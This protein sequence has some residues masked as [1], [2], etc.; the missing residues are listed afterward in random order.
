MSVAL[1]LSLTFF[2]LNKQMVLADSPDCGLLQDCTMNGFYGNSGAG[3]G[4]WKVFK[5]SGTPGID[6]APVEGWPS[7]PSVHLHG[8]D[9]PFDAGILQTVAVT[10]GLGY[11][12]DLAW[13]VETIGGKGWHDGYQIN[14][15]LGIDPLG[16]VDANS[17]NVQWSTDY[18]GSGKFVLALDAYAQAPLM[19]VFVRVINPYTDQV[20]DVYLD[21]ASL[22]VNSGMAPITV[23]APATT[24]PSPTAAPSSTSRP[25]RE[26]TVIALAPSPTEVALAP[27][28]TELPTDAPAPTGVVE[29]S[30]TPETSATSTRLPTRVRRLTPTPIA[31]NGDTTRTQGLLVIGATGLAGITVAG[32]LFVLAF[33]FWLRS[34]NR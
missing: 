28:S 8:T 7:G 26:P 33:F 20:V 24:Q 29:P 11:H 2:T 3:S 9:A 14:R 4:P 22:Q 10:P 1:L 6:L 16:G 32:I 15:R 18:L 27:T 23:N 31:E 34:K 25:T 13:A 21:T 19:T 5:L 30:G 17:P 12:F